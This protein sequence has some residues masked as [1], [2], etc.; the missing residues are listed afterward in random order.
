M[1]EHKLIERLFANQRF[2]N[3]VMVEQERL[4]WTLQNKATG[5][6]PWLVTKKTAFWTQQIWL[7]EHQHHLQSRPVTKQ[8]ASWQCQGKRS[9]DYLG[10]LAGY[11]DRSWW[12]IRYRCVIYWRDKLRFESLRLWRADSENDTKSRKHFGVQI[13]LGGMPQYYNKRFYCQ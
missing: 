12:M 11:A 3:L 9:R 6:E 4:P 13:Q 7:L 10:G 1:L 8:W 5:E 2:S